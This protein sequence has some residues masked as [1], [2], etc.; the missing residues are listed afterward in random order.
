M[1]GVTGIPGEAA[2][3]PAVPEDRR[4]RG[5][6]TARLQG[7]GATIAAGTGL[8]LETATP[9]PA[10]GTAA[11][12]PTT[13]HAAPPPTPAVKG[14]ETATV[15]ATAAA[16]WCVAPT[17]ATGDPQLWTV[18]NSHKEVSNYFLYKYSL[19]MH[20]ILYLHCRL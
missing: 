5:G 18:V 10:P 20:N 6:A 2:A 7:R 9:T 4:G 14:T 17:T 16:T 19:T 8:R 3:K 12:T 1:A 13:G 11:P 15:T